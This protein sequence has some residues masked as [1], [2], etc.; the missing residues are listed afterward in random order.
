MKSNEDIIDSYH[1]EE[2]CSSPIRAGQG[3]MSV[4]IWA[5]RGY[6]AMNDRTYERFG[7][8]VYVTMMY[9]SNYEVIGLK[10]APRLM[11]NT[12]KFNSNKQGIHTIVARHFLKHYNIA[13]TYTIRFLEPKIRNGILILDL[14]QTTRAPNAGRKPM[15]VTS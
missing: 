2:F 14:H 7:R 6:L 13:P 4:S 3:E 15:L 12:V 11:P 1:W 9:E 5:R 8:P 10:A